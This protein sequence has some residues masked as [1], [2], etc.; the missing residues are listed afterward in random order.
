MPDGIP[1]YADLYGIVLENID[2]IG[3]PA[4]ICAFFALILSFVLRVIC[5][6]FGDYFYYNHTV[7]T[8]SRLKAESEDLEEDFRKKGGISFIMLAIGVMAVEYLPQFLYT[9]IY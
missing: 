9:L 2:K 4:V 5:G 1:T 6:V 7:S 8:V 3:V